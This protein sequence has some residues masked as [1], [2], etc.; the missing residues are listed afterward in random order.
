MI[1]I[2]QSPFFREFLSNLLYFLMRFN[3]RWG[4]N[5]FNEGSFVKI[6]CFSFKIKI[7]FWIFTISYEFL[8]QELLEKSPFNRANEIRSI[9]SL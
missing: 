7:G 3:V 9:Y 1:K 8:V 2:T 6:C 5:V 4:K